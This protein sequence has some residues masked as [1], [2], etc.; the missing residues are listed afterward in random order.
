MSLLLDI[1]IQQ[2]VW[3]DDNDVDNRVTTDGGDV[4]GSLET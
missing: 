3:N 2:E 4:F 1:A